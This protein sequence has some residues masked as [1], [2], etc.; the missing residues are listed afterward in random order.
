MFA[1]GRQSLRRI[2]VAD[3]DPVIKH[4]LASIIEKEGCTAV[5][6]NDGRGAYRTLHSDADFKVTTF[7][8]MMPHLEGS[9]IIPHIKTEKRLMR[10]PVIMTISEQS[11][12]F[13]TRSFIAG[14][15]VFLSKPF[16]PEQLQFVLR[17]FLGEDDETSDF[18]K[19]NEVYESH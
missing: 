9:D 8:M 5:V 3:D 6:A 1:T 11:I 4:L 15:S 7:D 10:I 14:A 13:M 12:K 16:A 2:L 17:M 18:Q 19:A